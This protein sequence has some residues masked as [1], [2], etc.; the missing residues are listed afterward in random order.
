MARRLEY[1]ITGLGANQRHVASAE[2]IVIE[3]VPHAFSEAEKFQLTD[4]VLANL[5]NLQLTN[6]S[7]FN[8]ADDNAPLKDSNFTGCKTFPEDL[9]W[10]SKSVWGV[11]DLLTGS[12]LIETVPI[13]AVC[14]K[15][16]KHYNA[17]KCS[18]VLSEWTTSELHAQDPTSVMSPLY[19]GKTC[20]PENGNTSTCELGGFPSY[21][22]N[23]TRVSQI[24]LAVNFARNLNIRLVVHNTGHDFLGK[25]TGAGALSIWTHHLK[26]VDLITDYKSFSYS[27]PALKLGSGIQ[28][29][30]LY[31]AADKFGY[32][33][34]GGE[35]KGVGVT[36]GYLA[37]GGHSPLS[38]MYGMGSDQ[39]L[40]IDVVLPSGRF[41]TADERNNEDLF[42]ALRGGG[43]GT[44]GV[45]TSMT[46]KVYPKMNFSGMTFS[47]LSG[48]DTNI[49]V[50]VFWQAVAVYWRKLPSYVEEGSYGY[51]TIFPRGPAAA[52]NTWDMRPWLV[53][54]MKLIDFKVM[55]ASL[56]SEW[57]A[58]GFVVEPQYF[59][60]DNF[61]QTW[62]SHFPVEAVGNLN[63]RTA[64]RLFPKKNWQDPALLNKTIATIRAVAQEG[65]A[66]ILYNINGAKPAG[67]LDSAV[68]PA[69]R[70]AVLYVI[71]GSMWAE[72]S[73]KA[74]IEAVNKKVTHDWM[75]RFREITPGAGGYGNE[76]DVMEPDFA[77]AFYGSNYARLLSIKER[78]DPWGVFW[79]PTAVGSESWYVTGQEKWLTLQNGKL[80]RK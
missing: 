52:G 67:V 71:I 22:V 43:G 5:T 2:E 51:S 61:H 11:L 32:T 18:T 17:K 39:V 25:S 41:I 58:L 3:D 29:A 31:A 48:P 63:L 37:G 33:A 10:P 66:L 14:Y 62:T 28:V 1:S 49:S 9:S 12:S 27:G 44:F 42:W 70:E 6:I 76:G 15:N 23:A 46:V 4:A 21:V 38:S 7:L 74:E 30:D 50:E 13:G 54:G 56:L 78:I 55:V 80:C 8:F 57:E 45:V 75:E 40:S 68:N 47:V 20:M 69:W 65:S 36:G 73:T 77:Q 64:S 19:Q 72:G 35:C 79:A 26:S 53:P 59:E 60:H 24:Q 34:V 16:N